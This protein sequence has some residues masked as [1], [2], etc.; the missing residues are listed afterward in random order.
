LAAPLGWKIDKK[1]RGAIFLPRLDLWA[2]NF[3]FQTINA[4]I[5]VSYDDIKK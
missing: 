1:K 2:H 4:A 3:W 5:L